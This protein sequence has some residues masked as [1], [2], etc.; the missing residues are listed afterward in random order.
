MS[1]SIPLFDHVAVRVRERNAC[2][3]EAVELLGWSVIDHTERL[4]LLGSA[5]EAG[6]LTLLD[7]TVPTDPASPRVVGIVCTGSAPA[8][9]EHQAVRHVAGVDV[10]YGAHIDGMCDGSIAGV[11][12]A[13]PDVD[14]ATRSLG[15]LPHTAAS[16]QAG[17]VAI[18]TQWIQFVS[19]EEYPDGGVM[20]DHLG[21]RIDQIDHVL[22]WSEQSDVDVER[23]EA[24]RSSA[25]FMPLIASSRMEYIEVHAPA[26][27]A[28][29]S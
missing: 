12:I 8:P 7:A 3:D 28:G 18:G 14:A 20:L 26:R 15:A 23:V 4:T 2:A 1:S 29:R 19:A 10:T 6:K 27:M 11:T 24:A 9:D 22:A 16:A 13:V 25:L 5:D 21:V 17:R